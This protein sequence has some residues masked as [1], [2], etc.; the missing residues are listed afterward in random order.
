MMTIGGFLS[1]GSIALLRWVFN[2]SKGFLF[3]SLILLC[4]G[5]FVFLVKALEEMQPVSARRDVVGQ[6]GET[7]NNLGKNTRGVVRI[8]G[9]LWSAMSKT[10][11]GRNQKVRVIK[12]EGLCLW[13]EALEYSVGAGGQLD[14]SHERYTPRQEPSL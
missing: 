11:I 1:L 10:E 2:P 4:A 5:A 3:L 9:E 14:F 7:V 8:R 6:V 12:S 13:V